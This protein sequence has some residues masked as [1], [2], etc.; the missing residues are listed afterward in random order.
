M[1]GKAHPSANLQLQRDALRR[2]RTCRPAA[3]LNAFL[4]MNTHGLCGGAAAAL[5]TAAVLLGGCDDHKRA[6]SATRPSAGPTTDRYVAQSVIEAA[7]SRPVD[8]SAMTP[9]T[10]AAGTPT[11]EPRQKIELIAIPFTAEVPRSWTV[12]AGPAGK[13]VLAGKLSNGEAEILLSTRPNMTPES[14][15][16]LV[17]DLQAATTQP[18]KTNVRTRVTERDGMHIIEETER[19]GPPGGDPDLAPYRWTVQYI[20]STGGLD[21]GVY[22]MN[23]TSLS[24]AMFK[25]DESFLRTIFDSVTLQP[26]ALK[27]ATRPT[28]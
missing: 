2:L 5:V 24:E 27:A 22:E 9:I 19:M 28:Y 15:K 1:T 21:Y 17:K 16:S 25:Q 4:A 3:D 14:L 23:V 8:P 6:T 11:G 13:V 12:Q 20:V 18:A 10:A 26:E 7:S